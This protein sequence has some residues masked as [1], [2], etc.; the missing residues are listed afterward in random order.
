MIPHTVHISLLFAAFVAGGL[1][2]LILVSF[3]KE[4]PDEGEYLS[5]IHD[6]EGRLASE[7]SKMVAYKTSYGL[8]CQGPKYLDVAGEGAARIIKERIRQKVSEG[9]TTEHDAQH[10]EGELSIA[11]ACYA[12]WGVELDHEAVRVALDESDVDAWPWDR[13]WDK[14]GKHDRLRR[15][16]IAG[17]LIAAEIDRLVSNPDPMAAEAEKEVAH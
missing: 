15:L 5:R 2:T 16:E 14:R 4:G 7:H 11:A 6:L 10:L 9:W 8:L 12:V 3:F 17:A 13:E 1:V